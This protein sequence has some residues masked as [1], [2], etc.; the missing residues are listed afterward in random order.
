MYRVRLRYEKGGALRFVS[1]RDLMRIFRRAFASA[2]LP[3]S[4]SQ[5]FN[6]HPRLSF[7]PSLRTGWESLD[8][9]MDILFETPAG[10]IASRCNR[11][12]PDGLKVSQTAAVGASVPKLAA[13]VCG[14]AY[15][16]QLDE[17]DVFERR[18]DLRQPLLESVGGESTNG[19][20]PRRDRIL[21]ALAE[22]A[23]D[24][25]SAV[26]SGSDRASDRPNIASILEI[27]AST[28]D[29]ESGADIS[30]EYLST[31]HGGKSVFPEEILTPLLGDP[32]K[33]RTPVRVLRRSLFVERG[34]KLVSP[35]SRA[36]LETT[37]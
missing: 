37:V 29:P 14:A 8:E 15:V 13:D 18:V 16:I 27:Q 1:H 10:D 17:V 24:R 20:S 25:F 30:I 9:Y 2:E 31:M 28:G 7:G 12:L 34:G 33:Y 19:G 32:E 3:L 35:M 23:K 22:E 26:R 6:P 5:G 21:H 36:A 11:C 4:F